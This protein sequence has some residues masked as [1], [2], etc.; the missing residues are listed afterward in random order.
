MEKRILGNSDLKVTPI[1]FGTWEIGGEPFFKDQDEEKSLAILKEAVNNGM[2]SI[3]TAPVYGFGVAEKRVGKAIKNIREKI[4]ISTKCGLR[5]SEE[6]K[7]SI[8]T[9]ASKKSIIEEID[10]SLKR[11]DSDYI[12][13][14]LIHWPDKDTG[15]PIGESIETLEKL[16]SSGKIK[17]FGVSNFNIGQIKEAMRYGKLSAIQNQYSLIKPA[18]EELLVP[19][20]IQNSL[21][22]QIYSPLERGI[23]TDMSIDELKG[24]EESAV[25]WILKGVNEK[26]LDAREKLKNISKKYDVPFATFIIACTLKRP[27]MTTLLVG[28]KKI[29]HLLEAIKGVDLNISSEDLSSVD[30]IVAY[31]KENK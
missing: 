8:H 2:T 11:L 26:K 14:Y 23:L 16:K 7:E 17:S 18:L 20:A 5:W 31:L 19:F 29:E 15:T 3:D 24:K 9:N 10:L 12:D 22:I 1:S 27:G 28:T 30:S 21:G 6:K 25:D 13:L 4:F